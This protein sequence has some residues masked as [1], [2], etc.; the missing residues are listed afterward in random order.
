[1]IRWMKWE[2]SS[3]SKEHVLQL[4]KLEWFGHWME[5]VGARGARVKAA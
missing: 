1:M 5:N 2:W 3:C 4:R